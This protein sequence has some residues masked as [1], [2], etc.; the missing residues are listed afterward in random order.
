MKNSQ[1]G[2]TLAMNN[3]I[4]VM[5]SAKIDT[6]PNCILISWNLIIQ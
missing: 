2:S 5:F 6:V 1:I 4:L 3:L